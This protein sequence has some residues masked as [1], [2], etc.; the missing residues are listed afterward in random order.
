MSNDGDTKQDASDMMDKETEDN[1]HLS[2]LI[3]V[4]THSPDGLYHPENAPTFQQYFEKDDVLIQFG[5]KAKSEPTK[6]KKNVNLNPAAPQDSVEVTY[7]EDNEVDKF[8]KTEPNEIINPMPPPRPSHPPPK[9]F[10]KLRKFPVP[11]PGDYPI[12]MTSDKE[13]LGLVNV[14]K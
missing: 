3:S 12:N 13:M 2:S 4:H 7:I 6:E 9:Y 5:G 1:E 14:V 11:V 10:Q 8:N